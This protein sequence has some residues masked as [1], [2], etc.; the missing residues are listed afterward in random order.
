MHN[1]VTHYSPTNAQLISSRA[2]IRPPGQLPPVYILGMTSHGME[3]PIGQFGSAALAVS[4]PN[5]LC[6]SGLIAGWAGEAEKSLT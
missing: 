4:P 3:N 2:A 5:S 1:A 6:P